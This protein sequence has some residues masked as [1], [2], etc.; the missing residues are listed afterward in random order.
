M[1]E[2]EDINLT[3]TGSG[4]S[5]AEVAFELL[6]KLKGQGVWGER[7]MSAI[8]DMYAECLDA[9]KGLRAYE[10]QKRV[11]VAIQK[12]AGEPTLRAAP[13]QTPC[14]LYTSPSPRDRTRSRMPSS[15]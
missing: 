6:S 12:D 15:A 7:N 4:K 9:A 11:E 8:L 10:G 1:S 13:P 5:E 3:A 2:F 14:L